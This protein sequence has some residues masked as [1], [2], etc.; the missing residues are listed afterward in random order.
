MHAVGINFLFSSKGE[1]EENE[2][3][4]RVVFNIYIQTL[5]YPILGTLQGTNRGK[6]FATISELGAKRFP[7]NRKMSKLADLKIT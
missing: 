4:I 7:V 6:S 2:S 1:R 5:T 3:H